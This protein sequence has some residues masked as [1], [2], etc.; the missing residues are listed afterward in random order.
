MAQIISNTATAVM[1][2]YSQLGAYATPVVSLIV[3]AGALQLATVAKTKPPKFE[4]GGLVG[5]SR[6]SAGG[7]MI[8][9][10]QG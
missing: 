10:E 8:E 6:H 5:G 2:A 4:E 1:K 9:A 7:T 3:G